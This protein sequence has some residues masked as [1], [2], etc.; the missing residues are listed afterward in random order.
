M[1][2][3]WRC[4]CFLYRAQQTAE[5]GVRGF[6]FLTFMIS[7]LLFNWVIIALQCCVSFCC[8][9]EAWG[10]SSG[11]SLI[12]RAWHRIVNINIW[13][14]SPVS[15]ISPFWVT[16]S[17]LLLIGSCLCLLI[18]PAWRLKSSEFCN[19]TDK[20][21]GASLL[22]KFQNVSPSMKSVKALLHTVGLLAF[23]TSQRQRRA[24]FPLNSASRSTGGDV[25]Q[26]LVYRWQSTQVWSTRLF[27]LKLI[28]L[29]WRWEV[30]EIMSNVRSMSDL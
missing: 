28:D 26:S 8:K 19:Q 16:V 24:I 21:K 25:L 30:D 9:L 29:S 14:W 10:L 13:T 1:L 5:G 11:G 17:S 4:S 15:R 12:Q 18:W 7:V 20:G 3:P 2:N 22:P 27:C 6:L 23:W